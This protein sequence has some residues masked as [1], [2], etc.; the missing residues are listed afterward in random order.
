MYMHW[1]SQNKASFFQMARCF[2]VMRLALFGV[3]SVGLCIS[4]KMLHLRTI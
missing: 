3:T 1:R 4:F 2:S